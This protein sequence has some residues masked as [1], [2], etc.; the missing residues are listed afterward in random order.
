MKLTL[1]KYKCDHC[2]FEAKSARGLKT[3]K[4]HMHKDQDNLVEYSPEIQIYICA[5]CENSYHNKEEFAKHAYTHH[6][7]KN[8]KFSYRSH[9]I[10]K[11]FH[12][13]KTTLL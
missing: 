8:H 5:F 13:R 11:S 3:H 10:Y 2:S 9:H 4:G 1:I 12:Y 7:R 6:I